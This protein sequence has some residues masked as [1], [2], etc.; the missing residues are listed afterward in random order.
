MCAKQHAPVMSVKTYTGNAEHQPAY[1]SDVLI[2]VNF[3]LRAEPT[4]LTAVLIATA[5]PAAINPY[6]IAVAPVSSFR[7][8]I[9]V[10]M[11]I[12]PA[13]AAGRYARTKPL[14][15]HESTII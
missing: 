8:L 5:M 1:F 14:R 13:V 4:P 3:V 12:E 7:N 6:S 10:R 11:M 2:A 15:P 9:I